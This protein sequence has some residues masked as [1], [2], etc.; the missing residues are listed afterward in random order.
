MSTTPRSPTP[1]GPSAAIPELQRKLADDRRILLGGTALVLQVAHPVVGAGVAQHSN[2]KTHPWSRLN[3]TMVSLSKV[4]WGDERMAVGE[5]RR[6]RAFHRGISG[7]DDLGRNYSALDP[8]AY[9]WVLATLIQTSIAGIELFDRDRPD[10]DR[11]YQ[12]WLQVG[13][14]L[15]VGALPDSWPE[16]GAYFDAVVESTLE[17]NPTVTAVLDTIFALPKPRYVPAPAWTLV[18]APTG[19]LTKLVTI[20]TLPP[21]LLDRFGLPPLDDRGRRRFERFC[22]GVRSGFAVLPPGLRGG[23]FTASQQLANRVVRL[24]GA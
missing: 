8:A 13:Q 3:A 17:L 16:F 24:V 23:P 5:A 6:L 18:A 2:F 21:I 11:L 19:S 1:P 4:V 7:V 9:A 12:E 14:L 10:V 15:G 22:T 20:G